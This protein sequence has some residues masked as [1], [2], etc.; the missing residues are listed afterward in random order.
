M[1]AEMVADTAGGER[2][3]TKRL[4]PAA[5]PPRFGFTA[6]KKLGNAV[7]RNRIRRRLKEAVRLVAPGTAHA[8]CDYVLIAREAAATRPFA[9]LERDLAAA[10]AALHAPSAGGTRP[11]RKDTRGGSRPIPAGGR[12]G[13]AGPASEGS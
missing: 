7:I 5:L 2:E 3:V 13:R 4:A 9:A 11:A 10:F 6:T 12:T 8:G 1:R